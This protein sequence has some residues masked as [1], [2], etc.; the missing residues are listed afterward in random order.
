MKPPDTVWT[1]AAAF[2][3]ITTLSLIAPR[4]YYG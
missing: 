3:L 4:W 2:L 1:V